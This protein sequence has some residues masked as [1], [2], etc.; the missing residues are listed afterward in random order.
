MLP[1]QV[2]LAFA[3]SSFHA[4]LPARSRHNTEEKTSHQSLP[5]R[6]HYQPQWTRLSRRLAPSII[7]IPPMPLPNSR[8][9]SH[10]QP[11][12]PISDPKA[13]L[14][15]VSKLQRFIAPVR[16]AECRLNRKGHLPSRLTFSVNAAGEI[17]HID[18]PFPSRHFIEQHFGS[19]HWRW[20]SR[21]R[22]HRP[23]R[24]NTIPREP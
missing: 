21:P 2:I 20:H 9:Q 19:R 8:P 17:R 13:Q 16:H 10:R 6:L 15:L 3:P 7:G 23:R 5:S 18:T 24:M 22:R 11:S 4:A 12:L 1:S 14:R